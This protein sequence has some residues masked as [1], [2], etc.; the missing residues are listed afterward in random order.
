MANLRQHL[1]PLNS[2]VA[3]EA[4]ARHGSMTRAAEELLVTREAVSRQ[5]HALEEPLGTSL[6]VRV[7][8]AVELTADGQAFQEVVASGLGSIAK[9]TG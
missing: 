4:V 6:F 8:R 2:L 3:F 9:A 1:P 7:H 5:V